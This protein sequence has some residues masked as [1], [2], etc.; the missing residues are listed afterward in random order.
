MEHKLRLG[1]SGFRWISG[2]ALCL[3]TVVRA[4]ALTNVQTVFLIVMEN[5]S[6]SSIKGSAAAPYINN[7]LLPMASSCEQ[8][9]SPT[10]VA[11]SLPNYLILEGGTNLGITG[12]PTPTGSA[13]IKSTNHLATLLRNAGVSWRC[14]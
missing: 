10:G 2:F 3:A 8:Y 9:Y 14:Y 1:A 6:W 7:A 5:V 13:R 4:G 12:S 11:S